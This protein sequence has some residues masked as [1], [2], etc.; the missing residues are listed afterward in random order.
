[1]KLRRQM[2][3]G[4]GLSD[5]LIVGKQLVAAAVTWMSVVEVSCSL[6][7]VSKQDHLA[8]QQRIEERCFIY[9]KPAAQLLHHADIDT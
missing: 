6:W 9:N 8:E 5:M 3:D 1:M 7:K 2:R 4:W